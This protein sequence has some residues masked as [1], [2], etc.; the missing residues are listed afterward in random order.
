MIRVISFEPLYGVC[1]S[2]PRPSPGA[3]AISK[4]GSSV[5]KLFP[6]VGKLKRPVGK[7]NR[8]AWILKYPEKQ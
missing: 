8:V 4:P 3:E 1:G 6:P 5:R 2:V 7:V